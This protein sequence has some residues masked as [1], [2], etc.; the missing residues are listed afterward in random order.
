[1]AQFLKSGKK[2]IGE[3]KHCNDEIQMDGVRLQ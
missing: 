2:K 1:M 3:S